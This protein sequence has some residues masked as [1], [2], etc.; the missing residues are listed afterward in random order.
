MRRLICL[1]VSL[2]F[3]AQGAEEKQKP[4]NT[5]VGEEFKLGLE[6]NPATGNQWML[7]RPLDEH[8]LKLLGTPEYKRPHSGDQGREI[9]TFRA[10]AEG[11]TEIY[12]KYGK[13]FENDAPPARKTN[14]VVV[15][16][17]AVTR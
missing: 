17:R 3:L 5:V 11:R 14:F 9:L 2:S 12:L 8:L 13:L 16:T 7:A 1:V 4:I 15:I 10:L 6:S